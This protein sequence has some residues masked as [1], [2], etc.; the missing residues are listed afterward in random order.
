M[1]SRRF[2]VRTESVVVRSR[3]FFPRAELVRLRR[4]RILPRLAHVRAI[5][6]RSAGYFRA[7]PFNAQSEL[8]ASRVCK[9][10]S[11]RRRLG[12]RRQRTGPVALRKIDER[13]DDPISIA[14]I[15]ARRGRIRALRR[16]TNSARGNN[17][18]ERTTTDSVRTGNRRERMTPIRAWRNRRER[19][20]T[21]SGVER[22]AL[23]PP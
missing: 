7:W 15:W 21:N 8:N 11:S 13:G 9:I 17:R 1:R 5:E 10:S 6:F 20:T 18:R 14:R 12:S 16:R 4:A 22:A 19:M 2:P 3:R 23:S